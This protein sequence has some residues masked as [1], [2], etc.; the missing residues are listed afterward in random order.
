MED[1]LVNQ[2]VCREML[3]RL[4]LIVEVAGNG[5]EAVKTLE[6]NPYDLVLMD[7]QMPEMDGYEATRTIRGRE[8]GDNQACLPIVALTAHAMPGDRE[9]CLAAGMDDYLVKPFRYEELKALLARWL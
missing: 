7:C 2:L 5:R 3:L 6:T 8:Q 1:N 9:K 4:G